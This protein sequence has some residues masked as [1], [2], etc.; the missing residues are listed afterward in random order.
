MKFVNEDGFYDVI[1]ESR[2]P[3][4]RKFRKWVTKEVL[5]SIRKTGAYVQLEK[6]EESTDGYIPKFFSGIK[7]FTILLEKE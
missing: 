5:P 4:A 6:V 2:K 3:I 1:L 7:V